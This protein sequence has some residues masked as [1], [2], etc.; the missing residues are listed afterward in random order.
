[1]RV[2]SE[3]DWKKL[4]ATGKITAEDGKRIQHKKAGQPKSDAIVS[5]EEKQTRELGHLAEVI[6][7]QMQN[8]NKI[9]V[10]ITGALGKTQ[11]IKMP[12]IN[13]PESNTWEKIEFKVTKRDN[14]GQLERFTAERVS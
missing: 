5:V 14:K 3:E 13:I 1:M 11:D 12:E 10:A 9:A 7:Q 4:V 8:N 2:I 6:G